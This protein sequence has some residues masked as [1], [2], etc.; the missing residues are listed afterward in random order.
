MRKHKE[1]LKKAIDDAD[2]ITIFHHQYPDL[3]AYGSQLGLKYWLQSKYPEKKIY[4]LGG[5]HPLMDHVSD[6]LIKNSLAILT[7]CSTSAR[8]D[9]ERWKTARKTARID[10][11]VYVEDFCDIEVIDEDATATCEM[12]ALMA[13]KEE[14]PLPH[15]ASQKLYEG[16]IADNL[17]FST[18]KVSPATF[19]AAAYL[20]ENGANVVDGATH[21]FSSTYADFEYETMVRASS[22][23]NG[24]LLFSVMSA[25]DYLSRGMSFSSAKEKVYALGDISDIAIWALF[26]QMEDGIHYSASLRS[27]K[28][29]IR[30]IAMKFHGGGHDCA[31]GI[32]N[33]TVG[34]V[35]EVITLLAQR[36]QAA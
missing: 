12:I 14:D 32:K 8:V 27:R 20:L 13:K 21:A 36:A 35:Y 17:R 15:K 22:K 4:A 11:H 24:K 28:I 7:D 25:K 31:S 9:D 1:D 30:D 34:E 6:D 3:D 33:L 16:L 10:H 29:S 18:D 5:N 19:E 2:I 23:R 26:T